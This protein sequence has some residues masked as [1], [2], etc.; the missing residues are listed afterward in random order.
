MVLWLFLQLLFCCNFIYLKR[1]LCEIDEHQRGSEQTHLL[2]T[3]CL[4][5]TDATV[6]SLLLMRN[7][8]Y[9]NKCFKNLNKPLFTRWLFK[10]PSNPNHYIYMIFFIH[11]NKETTRN[12]WNT[13]AIFR[14]LSDCFSRYSPYFCIFTEFLIIALNILVKCWEGS[15]LILKSF[16]PYYYLTSRKWED[17]SRRGRVNMDKPWIH[18]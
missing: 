6:A 8:K 12:C 13:L 14:F 4:W 16:F 11:G 7:P 5:S 18:I 10:T 1:D 15:Q 3:S 17:R 9:S 2:E